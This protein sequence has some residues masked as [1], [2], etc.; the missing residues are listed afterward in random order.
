LQTGVV[1]TRWTRGEIAVGTRITESREF[2][3]C[4]VTIVY[5]LIELR[6][7]CRTVVRLIAGPLRGTA[8]YVCEPMAGGT[9]V[10]SSPRQ[11]RYMPG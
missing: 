1:Q 5:Q 3:G 4:S 2:A 11:V 10:P 8:S 9:N 6:W 7:P